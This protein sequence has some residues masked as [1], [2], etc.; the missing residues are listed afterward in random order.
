MCKQN[1]RPAATPLR[2]LGDLGI[3]FLE[4]LI[5]RRIRPPVSWV[6]NLKHARPT[7]DGL[8]LP[9]SPWQ[10]FPPEH[11]HNMQGAKND[12]AA[13][14]NE[15]RSGHFN[16]LAQDRFIAEG[17]SVDLLRDHRSPFMP[18]RLFDIDPRHLLKCVLKLIRVLSVYAEKPGH[19]VPAY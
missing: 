19:V 13:H 9:L 14:D 16:L 3:H 15:I 11:V 12:S 2:S 18:G 17:V 7:F 4:M 8:D 5:K 1:A 6:R 10:H